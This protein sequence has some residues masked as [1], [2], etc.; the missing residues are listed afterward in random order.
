MRASARS[1]SCTASR[2]GA[3]VV[4]MLR[5]TS[6][7]ADW[8]VSSAALIAAIAGFRFCFA[9]AWNWRPWRVVTR[10]V[11]LP[12]RSHSASMRQVLRRAARPAGHAH[13]HH[14]RK[15]LFQPLLLEPGRGVAVVLLVA[16]VEFQQVVGV[17]RNLR[18]AG[19]QF[20]GQCAAQM[21]GW[22]PSAAPRRSAWRPARAQVLNRR[23]ATLLPLSAGAAADPPC[24]DRGAARSTRPES[25]F[26]PPR[27]TCWGR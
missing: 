22:F 1:R 12:Q 8:V 5:T 21:R 7:H 11:P 17:L 15:I 2:R 3:G 26:A 23:A 25:A 27:W 19:R 14:E 24:A 6:P 9:T 10:S 4:V 13:A 16:A 18:A 20:L